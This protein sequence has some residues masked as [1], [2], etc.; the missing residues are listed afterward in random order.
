LYGGITG[1]VYGAIPPV[2][3]ATGAFGILAFI[4]YVRR[5]SAGSATQVS[6]EQW[7]RLSSG[8]LLLGLVA[9]LAANPF[10]VIR[11]ALDWLL[12][13]ASFFTRSGEGGVG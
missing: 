12:G 13:L 9:I 1:K 5:G 8:V 7:S 3:L 10:R 11:Q 2:A 4:V 6:K